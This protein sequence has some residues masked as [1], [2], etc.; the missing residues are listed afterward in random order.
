MNC[1]G[2]FIVTCHA[3]GPGDDEPTRRAFRMMTELPSNLE[4][5]DVACGPGMQTIELAR[6]CKGRITAVDMHQ[7]FLDELQRRAEAAGFDERVKAV[8]ASMFSMPFAR[9]TTSTSSVSIVFLRDVTRNWNT[10]SN[11]LRVQ[12]YV[13]SGN[14]FRNFAAAIFT[15]EQSSH[16]RNKLFSIFPRNEANKADDH[17]VLEKGMFIDHS[18]P[19]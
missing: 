14:R 17:D 12:C 4:I 13:S 8:N 9:F 2:K 18:M 3:R 6:I 10:Q 11:L 7:P 19:R 16:F 5:L 15:A 1:F